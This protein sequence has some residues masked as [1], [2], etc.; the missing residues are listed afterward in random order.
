M[1]RTVFQTLFLLG[2]LAAEAQTL[3]FSQPHGF[4]DEAFTTEI[5]CDTLLPNDVAI[6]YTLDGSEP[7]ASSTAY[8]QPLRVDGNTILRAAAIADT[9]CVTPI[10]SV[11]YLFL[12]DVLQQSNTPEG[13]PAEWGDYTEQWGA[14]IADYEM[15]A[16]MTSDPVL[17]ERRQQSHDGR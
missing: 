2:A 8:T 14:A 1:K 13:Y 5:K 7:T 4:Y 17:A 16:E 6:H 15:D 11:T 10:A 3:S 9:G 12:D